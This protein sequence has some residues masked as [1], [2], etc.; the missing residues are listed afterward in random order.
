MNGGNPNEALI[1]HKNPELAQRLEQSPEWNA[2]T[3][4][5]LE[6]R[7][8]GFFSHGDE[9]GDE[10]DVSGRPKILRHPVY[11]DP[12]S[13]PFENQRD[14]YAPLV[15]QCRYSG[16]EVPDDLWEYVKLGEGRKY[17]DNQAED[18]VAQ[19]A[20]MSAFDAWVRRFT[21]F[22]QRK[23]K[24][25]PGRYRAYGH[26]APGHRWADMKLKWRELR[27]S[28]GHP[29]AGSSPAKQQELGLNRD[30]TFHPKEPE[31]EKSRN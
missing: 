29:L 28:A 6:G 10:I 23:G 7:T 24:V 3:L 1:E 5:H 13:E 26:E 21:D 9:G 22:V 30:A 4:N 31:G 11:F 8:A 18:M 19:D 20:V 16:I 2:L 27:M 25:E 17:S 14:A 12:D 15:W